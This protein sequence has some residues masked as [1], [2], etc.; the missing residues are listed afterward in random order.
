VEESAQAIKETR[1]LAIV[2]GL[3]TGIGVALIVNAFIDI[4]SGFHFCPAVLIFGAPVVVFGIIALALWIRKPLFI[5]DSRTFVLSFWL[6][7]FSLYVAT[8]ILYWFLRV[9]G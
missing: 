2:M 9:F 8:T 6:P 3:L 4:L 7:F 1:S 5:S